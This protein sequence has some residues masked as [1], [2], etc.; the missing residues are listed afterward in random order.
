M[1]DP[2]VVFKF[3]NP[4]RALAASI[5]VRP[6][7]SGPYRVKFKGEGLPLKDEVGSFRLLY[8]HNAILPAQF[9]P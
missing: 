2:E 7:I 5:D 8:S 9:G 3:R 6:H 1:S 4:D